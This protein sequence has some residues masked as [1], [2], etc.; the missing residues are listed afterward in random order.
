MKFLGMRLGPRSSC[1]LTHH[2]C[3]RYLLGLRL[4]RLAL[5]ELSVSAMYLRRGL[6]VG[7]VWGCKFLFRRGGLLLADRTVVQLVH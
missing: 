7:I 5:E 3:H 1:S 4:S 6:V 2:H